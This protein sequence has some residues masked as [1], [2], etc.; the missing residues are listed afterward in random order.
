MTE[1]IGPAAAAVEAAA[2]EGPAAPAVE[3]AAVVGLVA[4]ALD[5]AAGTSAVGTSGRRRL[6]LGRL[7]LGR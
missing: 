1:V 7:W 6:L 5:A 3:A 2:V 4:A